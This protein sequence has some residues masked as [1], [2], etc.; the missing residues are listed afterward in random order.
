MRRG[1]IVIGE[2]HCNGCGRVIK[3]PERYLA[4]DEESG[5]EVEEGETFRYCVDCCLSRGFA[6]YRTEKGE[7]VLTFIE[8]EPQSQ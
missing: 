2:V 7:T 1:C 8:A 6:R 5:I 3:H 4:I